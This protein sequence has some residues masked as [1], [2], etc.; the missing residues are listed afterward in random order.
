MG[1][2]PDEWKVAEAVADRSPS[3]RR[4]R[5]PDRGPRAHQS[6]R[7][8][9]RDALTLIAPAALRSYGPTGALGARGARRARIWHANESHSRSILRSPCFGA[10]Q[11]TTS[12]V[13]SSLR[14]VCTTS[15]LSAWKRSTSAPS[16]IGPAAIAR[17]EIF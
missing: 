13:A 3:E 1:A 5:S 17:P 15:A 12:I 8:R 14:L 11:S 7:R 10:H 2:G 4:K 6:E 16:V 9:E